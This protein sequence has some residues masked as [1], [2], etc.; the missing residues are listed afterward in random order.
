MFHLWIGVLAFGD[1]E[2]EEELVEALEVAR[3]VAQEQMQ[4]DVQVMVQPIEGGEILT[5]IEQ[6][7]PVVVET[8]IPDGDKRWEEAEGVVGFP[9]QTMSK[10]G[11]KVLFGRKM[12]QSPLTFV[13]GQNQGIH[14]NCNTSK[15]AWH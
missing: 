8:F 14:C 6:A 5:V 9:V 12:L 11:D 3:E 2:A 7:A 4:H 10:A 1:E 13:T 15:S